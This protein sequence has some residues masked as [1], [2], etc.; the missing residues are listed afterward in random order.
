M[1]KIQKIKFIFGKTIVF[2]NVDIEDAKFIF[3][4]RSN[5]K[6]SLY[7]NPPPI[8]LDDQKM[9]IRNYEK[10]QNEAYFIIEHQNK[11]IGTVRMYD[12]K[13]SSFAWGSWILSDEAP[14]NSA[15]E[16]T[17]IIYECGFN[18]LGFDKSHFDVKKNNIK[19]WQFHERLGAKRAS[20]DE[21][22]Y[23]YQLT[24]KDYIIKQKKYS[25]F[26]NT[27]N[28]IFKKE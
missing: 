8:S 9:W 5:P 16:S 24:K 15:I 10:T 23:Y 18:F 1:P 25:K 2:R 20:E 7:L 28:I 27:E 11:K 6:K 12:Q 22:N 19:V 3:D 26:L 21:I 13:S 17:L 4:L 14:Y